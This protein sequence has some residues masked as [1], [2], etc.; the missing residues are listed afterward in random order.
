MLFF[1]YAQR[2]NINEDNFK[3]SN[4]LG[5]ED[6]LEKGL[7][8]QTSILACKIPWMEEPGR[9]QSMESQRVGHG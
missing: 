3:I 8:T 9:P 6:P 7:A 1:F 2:E 5:W 4:S